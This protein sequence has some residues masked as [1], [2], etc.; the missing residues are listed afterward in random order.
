MT[1]QIEKRFKSLF[2]RVGGMAV[3]IILEGIIQMASDGTIAIPSPFI[4]LAGLIVGEI[5]KYINTKTK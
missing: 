2:W 4:I 5:T 3:A 1:E